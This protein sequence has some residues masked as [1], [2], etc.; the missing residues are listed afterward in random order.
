M[1]PVYERTQFYCFLRE[2]NGRSPGPCQPPPLPDSH[3]DSCPFLTLR[4]TQLPP[5]PLS[6]SEGSGE[7]PTG[8]PQQNCCL[9][10]GLAAPWAEAGFPHPHTGHSGAER[11]SLGSFWAE[12]EVTS[13]H[14]FGVGRRK[15]CLRRDAGGKHTQLGCGREVSGGHLQRL[16]ELGTD[17]YMK[18]HGRQLREA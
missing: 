5:L 12:Q 17:R 10:P 14:G 9:W 15:G 18:H 16:A 1:V 8:L 7:T 13:E 2:D 6:P 11:S 4:T 3:A